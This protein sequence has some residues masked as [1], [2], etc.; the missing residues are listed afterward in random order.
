LYTEPEGN[1]EYSLRVT[2]DLVHR[3]GYL[4]ANDWPFLPFH[5]VMVTVYSL[6]G[7]FWL[8]VSAMYWRDLLR[9]QLWIG[10]VILL[11]LMEK[12]AYLYEYEALNNTGMIKQSA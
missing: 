11:G 7:L 4:S 8:V 3:N 9:L 2:L 10:A 1:A 5:A 6:Y 12:A